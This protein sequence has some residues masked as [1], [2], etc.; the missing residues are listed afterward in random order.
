M[1]YLTGDIHGDLSRFKNKNIKKL[2]KNDTLIICG[3]FG[4][5]WNGSKKE[6]RI[7][8][9]LGKKKYNILFVEG[10][11]ENYDLLYNYPTEEYCGG[12]VR[13]IS[14]KLR[15]MVRGSIFTIDGVKIFAFGGGQQ[16]EKDIRK[17]NNTY[18]PQELPTQEELNNALSNL[19]ENDNEVDY[20]VTHE[21]PEFIK[22]FIED[23]YNLISTN[24]MNTTFNNIAKN[25]K[26]KRWYFGKCH[27]NKVIPPRF[28]CVFT[29]IVKLDTPKIKKKKR[30]KNK[31]TN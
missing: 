18:W 30:R 24:E 23:N 13:K 5:I 2:K 21:P 3:D 29:N 20:I 10:C 15:Q 22:D 26:F 28:E 14:G 17:Q 19:K 6:K 27:K 8:K 12:T 9:K 11:H 7:L 25:C 31:N 4:F 16:Y 1:I